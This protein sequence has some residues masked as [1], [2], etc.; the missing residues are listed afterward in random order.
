[1][2]NQPTITEAAEF[3][4]RANSPRRTSSNSASPHRRYEDRVKAWVYIDREGRV[5][6][7]RGSPRS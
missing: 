4:A 6:R 2:Q 1:M 3:I 5:D 7:L